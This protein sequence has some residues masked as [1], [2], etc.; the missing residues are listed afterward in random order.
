M[1]DKTKEQQERDK[2]IEQALKDLK[3]RL[4][5]RMMTGRWL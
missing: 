1:V 2:R 4:V 3:D 5:F